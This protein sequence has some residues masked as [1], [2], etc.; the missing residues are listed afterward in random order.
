MQIPFKSNHI[1]ED[2]SFEALEP[3]VP[4]A[5]IYKQEASQSY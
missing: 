1:L 4:E 3:E 5:Y 2:R